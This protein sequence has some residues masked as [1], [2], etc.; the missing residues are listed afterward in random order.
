MCAACSIG[1][2]LWTMRHDGDELCLRVRI[3]LSKD[4][5]EL[6]GYGPERRAT[7]RR[8]FF[9]REPLE[10]E[11][12]DQVFRGCRA[13]GIAKLRQRN[14]QYENVLVADTHSA[15]PGT[16]LGL[17]LLLRLLWRVAVILILEVRSLRHEMKDLPTAHVGQGTSANRTRSLPSET[18]LL[19]D[20]HFHNLARARVDP[21]HTRVH[22]RAADRILE[23]VTIATIELQA[24]VGDPSLHLG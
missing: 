15:Y 4:G 24:G 13:L 9:R 1:F 23:H 17:E 14:A 6:R 10:H 5:P 8:D 2:G 20:D 11:V 21:L 22:V 19:G 3:R 7:L 12:D 16:C 18:H